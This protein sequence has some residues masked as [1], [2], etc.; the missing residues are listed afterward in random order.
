MLRNRKVIYMS[1][2]QQR[3]PIYQKLLS[4]VFSQVNE[5]EYFHCSKIKSHDKQSTNQSQKECL[6]T[7][8]I[9][10]ALFFKQSFVKHTPRYSNHQHTA[11]NTCDSFKRT[12]AKTTGNNNIDN[13]T[14]TY[15]NLI[16][17]IR[18]SSI[19]QSQ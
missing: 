5:K 7:L 19:T 4:F 3:Q 11:N 8:T 13:T 16:I 17:S 14:D 10:F 15:S 2:N 1:Q 18:Q 9:S 12:T 6:N